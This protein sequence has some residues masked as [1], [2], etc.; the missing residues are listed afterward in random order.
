MTAAIAGSKVRSWRIAIVTM[1]TLLV[2]LAIFSLHAGSASAQMTSKTLTVSAA[3]GG[4]VTV[5]GIDR[6]NGASYCTEAYPAI[7]DN[8]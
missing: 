1:V 8:D 6:G 3:G 5:S 2:A 4:N 7:L